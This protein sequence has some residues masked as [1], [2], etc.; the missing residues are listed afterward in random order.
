MEMATQRPLWWAGHRRTIP[1]QKK[2]VLLPQLQTQTITITKEEGGVSVL[3]VNTHTFRL[4][5]YEHA[6]LTKEQE[7]NGLF[8]KFVRPSY[9]YKELFSLN[10]LKD[11]GVCVLQSVESQIVGHDLGLNNNSK[12][13]IV[14]LQ[15]SSMLLRN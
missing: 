13:S 3:Q 7:L 5:I 2:P 6:V 12:Y 10:I 11:R 9:L 14:P 1:Q 15:W 8:S 4:H